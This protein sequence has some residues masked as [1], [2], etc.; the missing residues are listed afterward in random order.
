MKHYSESMIVVKGTGDIDALKNAA[1]FYGFEYKSPLEIIDIADWNP[2]SRKRCGTAKLA[3]TFDCIKHKL[4]FETKHLA[5]HLPLD[6]AHDPST[7]ASMTLL[8]A[9]YIQGQ[10]PN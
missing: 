3:G 5:D 1:R 4:D 10:V 7:D 8:V 6:K 9:L 2:Q